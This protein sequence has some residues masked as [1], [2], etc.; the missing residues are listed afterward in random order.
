[1][2]EVKKANRGA[3]TKLNMRSKKKFEFLF[4]SHLHSFESSPEESE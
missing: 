4:W 1:M 3:K 2:N